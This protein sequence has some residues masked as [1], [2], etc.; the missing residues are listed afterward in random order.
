MSK[1]EKRLKIEVCRWNR[2]KKRG[3]PPLLTVY[4]D[5]GGGGTRL[6]GPKTLPGDTTVIATF[7]LDRRAV[8]AI[9]QDFEDAQDYAR[10]AE[11]R[12]VADHEEG[13]A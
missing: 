13:Q 11:A 12:I 3:I 9:A 6:A 7:Y 2:P 4:S 8:E 5:S 10:R 1:D